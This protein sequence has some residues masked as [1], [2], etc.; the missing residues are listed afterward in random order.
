L[1]VFALVAG[2]GGH[3][4]HRASATSASC[5]LPATGRVASHSSIS[6]SP[7]PHFWAEHRAGR[8][9]LK[10]DQPGQLGPVSNYSGALEIVK[11]HPPL[12]R[13]HVVAGAS[14]L[15]AVGWV[16]AQG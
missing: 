2:H 13:R 7:S 9:V 15:A 5:R 8:E 1:Q 16:P 11:S 12:Q 3:G 10:L 6:L 4:R 14:I